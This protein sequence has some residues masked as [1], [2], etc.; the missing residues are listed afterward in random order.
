MTIRDIADEAGVSV[1]TVSRLI[2]NISVRSGNAEKIQAIIDKYNYHPNSI[3]Q[4]LKNKTTRTIGYLV[5]DI[6]N[7][8]LISLAKV[9]ENT[10][11]RNKYNIIVCSTDNH[12][13]RELEYLNMLVSKKVDAIILNSTGLNNEYVAGISHQVPVILLHRRNTESSFRGDFIDC[14]NYHGSYLLTDHLLS[15][16]HRKIACISGPVRLSNA[17]ERY[18]GFNDALKKYGV[19][20]DDS[21]NFV[22]TNFTYEDG[23]NAAAELLSRKKRPT[24]IISMNNVMTL[25][26][27]KY[28]LE[29]N[30][31]APDQCSIGSFGTIQRSE[32]Y[33][34]QPT[35]V[36][37]DTDEMGKMAAEAVLSR[38]EDNK[39]MNR[40]F[41]YKP[42]LVIGNAEKC[43][44]QRKGCGQNRNNRQI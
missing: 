36:T 12:A 19:Y 21:E 4:S 13:E 1:A 8:Y 16:G 42:C 14:D 30:I 43:L 6:S 34:I 23:F 33:Y 41:I 32:L 28:F 18:N 15:L 17:A 9:I 31:K 24:A 39:I 22:F 27:M 11:G 44:H 20:Q 10:L 37:L 3:A 2:N 35:Y 7:D 38:I 25:G 29:S 26:V 40:D 5:S